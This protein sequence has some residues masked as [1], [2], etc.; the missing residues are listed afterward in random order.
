MTPLTSA[1]EIESPLQ[2]A[3]ARAL[4]AAQQFVTDASY[5][6]AA[7]IGARRNFINQALDSSCV[8]EISNRHT[9]GVPTLWVLQPEPDSPP[10]GAMRRIRPTCSHRGTG[11]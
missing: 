5:T 2:L 9:S 10:S 3:H 8:I 7:S 11:R 6:F 1:H 4:D